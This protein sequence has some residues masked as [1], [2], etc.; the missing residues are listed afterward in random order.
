VRIRRWTADHL[1]GIRGGPAATGPVATFTRAHLRGLR[2][3]AVGVAV[4]VFVFME[5]P[6]GVTI[7]VIAALL[8]VAL[9]AIEFLARPANIRAEP[10]GDVATTGTTTAPTP[11]ASAATPAPREG[12][13][14]D[15]SASR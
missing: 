12:E 1:H 10:D 15:V 6:T 2:I 7:L 3:G 4:L 14:S 9:A 8:L 13:G 11:V 5:Q